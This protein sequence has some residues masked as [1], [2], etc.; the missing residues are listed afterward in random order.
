M[1][2]TR[3]A[4][5]RRS[6]PVVLAAL[7][8]T[9]A[10]AIHLQA[11]GPLMPLIQADTGWTRQQVVLG[12]SIISVTSIFLMPSLGILADRLGA[13]NV[14]IP[15]LIIYGLG[16]LVLSYAKG[17]APWIFG[18]GVL[19]VALSAVQTVWVTGVAGHFEKSR[20]LAIAL[21]VSGS[22]VAAI[23]VPYVTTILAEYFGWRGALQRLALFPLVIA[24]PLVLR[25][26]FDGRFERKRKGAAASGQASLLRSTGFS[27]SEILRALPFWQMAVGGLCIASAGGGVA[28]HIVPMIR[29]IG[30]DPRTAAVI[31]SS[32]G[33]GLIAGRLIG[34]IM[35]DRL[36]AG[37]V[38]AVFAAVAAGSVAAIMMK[39]T[40]PALLSGI[41]LLFGLAVGAETDC[42]A[43]MIGRYFGFK[44]FGFAFSVLTTV[45]GLA[46]G[47]MSLAI[48]A[49]YDASHHYAKV[50]ALAATTLGI[51]VL[52]F[53]TLPRYPDLA[54]GRKDAVLGGH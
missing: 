4:E 11:L 12:M 18:W 34:G 39:P 9:S 35:I 43:Y 8:G 24:L 29:E 45:A 21:T 53:G 19:A 47:V 38:A 20:G 33:F 44:N 16:L 7:I 31:A 15:G 40:E 22:G 49:M 26:F 32:S 27:R 46:F 1:Q 48:G 54:P 52:A 25:F 3:V 2:M 6:W 37:R 23:F 50:Q 36:H 17:M 30:L 10:I 14:A 51:A 28:L 13:R 41:V 5:W 42:I